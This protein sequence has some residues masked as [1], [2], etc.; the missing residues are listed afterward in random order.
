MKDWKNVLL[1]L[2]CV[3]CLAGI[4]CGGFVDRIT[5]C[6][7]AE[8]SME[9]AEREFPPLGIMT[10]Y[11]AKQIKERIIIKHRVSQISAKRIAEDDKYEHDD[12]IGFI[13]ANITASENFQEIVVGSPDNPMS[14]MGLLG[15]SGLGLLAGRMMKRRG[16][17]SPA[18]VEEVVAKAK[19]SVRNGGQV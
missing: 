15:T 9:Y 13:N 5:P 14:L 6:E 12:A 4:S 2:L 11:E 1:A 8:Q 17:Y 18:E 7:V 16:D 19:T 10:L 3:V